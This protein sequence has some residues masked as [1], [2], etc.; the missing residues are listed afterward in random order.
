MKQHVFVRIACPPAQ[1]ELL[2]AT[3]SDVGF[4]NFL[5]EE[6]YLEAYPANDHYDPK[7]VQLVLEQYG[8]APDACTEHTVDE[9]NWNESWEK[10]FEPITV[11]NQCRVRAT[12][13]QADSSY[14]YEI[15]ISPKMAFG[16]GHHATTYL[17]LQEQ[18]R[19]SH[20]KKR[21][22]DAGCGTGILSV[23]A[24]Q[25]G[26]SPVLAFDI[27]EWAVNNARE[28]LALNDCTVVELFQGTIADVKDQRPFDL[29]LANINRN[30]LLAEMKQ[31]A[32]HLKPGGQLLLSGF[33]EEDL[34]LMREAI[35]AAGLNE[36]RTDSR[37]RWVVML[38][39]KK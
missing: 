35:V 18:L 17:M 12:F 38:V 24:K 20:T 8:I 36:V 3:L 28:N 13:H 1:H 25:R 4:D 5:E 22:M 7:A 14:P 15:V 21:V 2:I 29:I 31:Y 39:G 32:H 34:A 30:V 10:N 16:T 9:Q 33:Y 23:M 26:A 19:L 6:T 27:D 11:G 37:D